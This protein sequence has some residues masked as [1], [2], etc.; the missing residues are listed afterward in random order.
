MQSFE[1]L[2]GSQQTTQFVSCYLFP[3]EASKCSPA[4]L[5]QALSRARTHTHTH[6]HTHA[7]K[8]P[9]ASKTCCPGGELPFA[10]RNYDAWPC[11]SVFLL[12]SDTRAKG[13]RVQLRKD[14]RRCTAA[15]TTVVRWGFGSSSGISRI[16]LYSSICR[17]VSCWLLSRT[18]GGA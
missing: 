12:S 15:V 16:P 10:C 4:H 6:T 18:R 8:K 14:H 2:H 11:S 9:H 3:A 13:D 17:A 7:E 5:P 1:E